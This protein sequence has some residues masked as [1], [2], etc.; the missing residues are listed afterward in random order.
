MKKKYLETGKIVGTHGVKGA[1]RVQPWA[2]NA[3]FL[4]KFK[5][6]YLDN[7]G[8]SKLTVEQ[9]KPA[10]TIVIVKFKGIDSVPE[11][12]TLRNKII[13][14]NRDDAKLPKGSYF[15]EDL[16]GIEVYNLDDNRFLGK[17]TDVSFTG[18]ND[19]W[20]IEKDGKEYLFPAVKE[21]IDT[22]DIDG[23]KIVIKPIKG[24]FD[25]AD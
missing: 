14:I 22:I 8:A 6:F 23:E 2:D 10:N 9:V 13:Y 7:N 25:D 17:I 11:A 20:H 21:M 19:V 24:I 4:K 1:V 5:V 3:D 12:E 15:I 18:A 16:F